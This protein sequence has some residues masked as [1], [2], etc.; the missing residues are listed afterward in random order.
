[1]RQ[2][3]I[4]LQGNKTLPE[5]AK[6]G[7]LVE[8][9]GFDVTSVYADPGYQPAIGPLLSIAQA[10]SR[11]TLGPAGFNPYLIHPVEIAGQIAMLDAASN[12]RAYLGLVPRQFQSGEVDINGALLKRGEPM[13]AE[14]AR[15]LVAPMQP[16]ERR[17][18]ARAS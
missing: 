12:G 6:L 16:M 1:M 4:A 5:Y 13:T 3:S 7:T 18:Q 17:A 10:T 14:Q 11:I 8:A 15:P 2:V 9:L